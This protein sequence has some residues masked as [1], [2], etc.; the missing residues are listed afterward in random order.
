LHDA[1]APMNVK[2]P[3]VMIWFECLNGVPPPWR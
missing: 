3:N 1:V 2:H